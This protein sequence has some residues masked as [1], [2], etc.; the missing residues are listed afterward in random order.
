[1][2]GVQ[3]FCQRCEKSHDG[4]YGSGRFCSAKCAR[5]FSTFSKRS[6][7]NEKVS[8]TLTGRKTGY[9]VPRTTKNCLFC[10]KKMSLMPGQL[11]KKF[12]SPMCWIKYTE[13]NK[14]SFLLYRQRCKFKFNVY[15]YP[16]KF[17]LKLLEQKGWYSPSNRKNN[18]DGISRDHMLSISEGF[19]KGVDPDLMSHP[20]NCNLVCHRKNQSKRSKSSITFEEL[21]ERIKEW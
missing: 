16:D 15:D 12:C 6:E 21:V 20:A 11:S 5:S 14:D 17:D 10:E 4:K 7:I 19:S 13:K 9:R 2:E 8:D 3:M 1:M 18:L